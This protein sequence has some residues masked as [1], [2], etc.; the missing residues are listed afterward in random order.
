MSAL[1]LYIRRYTPV[2]VNTLFLNYSNQ[3]TLIRLSLTNEASFSG[4]MR[5]CGISIVNRDTRW[6]GKGAAVLLVTL[7]CVAFLP[8]CQSQ[9][10]ERGIDCKGCTL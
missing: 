5:P 3:M 6:M 10:E 4:N 1:I 8:R 9:G 2:A 7:T